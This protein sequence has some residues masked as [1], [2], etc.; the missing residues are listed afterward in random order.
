MKHAPP[1]S[2]AAT[3]LVIS[4]D[5][6]DSIMQTNT[7]TAGPLPA[8]LH[9]DL[10]AFVETVRLGTVSEAARRMRLSQP[11]LSA[12]INRLAK[13]TGAAL[14]RRE[15]RLLVLTAHG[16]RVHDG[17]LRVLRSCEAM[18]A[19]LEG[20][21]GEAVPL[22][23]GTAD[24]VPKIVSRRILMPLVKA[25]IRL[26][27]RE[28]SAEAMLRELASHRLDML[29]TD[30]EPV[31][32]RNEEHAVERIEGSPIEFCVLASLAPAIRRDFPRSLASV[33]LGLPASPSPLRDRLDRW[34]ARHVPGARIAIEAED[35]ALLHHFAQA[36]ACA[37]PVAKSTVT[38]IE[39]G[40][41]L[42][43]VGEPKGVEETCFVVRSRWRM[44]ETRE[45]APRRAA[46]E[47]R[48]ARATGAS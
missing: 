14:F 39:R 30:R 32:L 8:H 46:G 21:A 22:R 33:P 41:G 27:C 31:G 20:R 34:I 6:Y 24:A 45:P 48:G 17:A 7:R 3:I 37:V 47:G 35:R 11:A 2:T 10:A 42:A 28:W 4:M 18:Q 25:G 13:S 16:A 36:G 40:F 38:Q 26:E 9:P 1:R 5:C 19:V 29:I 12:R 43:R 23:V 44:P 15:G